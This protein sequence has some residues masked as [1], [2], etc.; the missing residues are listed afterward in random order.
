MVFGASGEQ[1]MDFRVHNAYWEPVD[2]EG[3]KMMLRPEC[4]SI[5]EDQNKKIGFSNASKY[6]KAATHNN[7]PYEHAA[8][9]IPSYVVLDIETTGLN[10]STDDIIEIGAI[11]VERG[12]VLEKMQTLVQG[13]CPVPAEITQLTGITKNEIEA[14]GISLEAAIRRLIDFA[15]DLPFICHNA[16]F[17]EQFLRRA[18]LKLKSERAV[19]NRFFD[20]MR[21]AQYLMP[22]M[23]SYKLDALTNHFG[24]SCSHRHRALDDCEMTYR[25]YTKLKELAYINQQKNE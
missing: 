17:E 13:S 23:E 3:I 7:I 24:I 22:D 14:F 18:C 8:F 19:N 1:H 12:V 21:M 6:R 4:Q 11:L 15:E 2:F 20:T 5:S 16:L 25:V 9:I 10:E